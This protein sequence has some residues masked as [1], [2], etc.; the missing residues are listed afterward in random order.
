MV[1]V[2]PGRAGSADDGGNGSAFPVRGSASAEAGAEDLAAA[3]PS[4]GGGSRF[5]ETV[6]VW[7]LSLAVAAALSSA[8]A[9][10]G[11]SLRVATNATAAAPAARPASVNQSLLRRGLSATGAAADGSLAG[12][13]GASSVSRSV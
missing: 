6:G 2:Q 12:V 3:E 11:A 7:P 13:P 1:P 10:A 8:G 5:A 4:A 9:Y